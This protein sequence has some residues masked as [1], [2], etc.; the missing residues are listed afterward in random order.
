[1]AAVKS[2]APSATRCPVP[3]TPAGAC[4]RSP[5]ATTEAPCRKA[6]RSRCRVAAQ[7]SNPCLL[8][9]PAELPRSPRWGGPRTRSLP[10]ICAGLALQGGPVGR[11]HR[12][13]TAFA[14]R[15]GGAETA[16]RARGAP[17]TE[18]HE[19]LRHPCTAQ[20][21]PRRPRRPRQDHA[22][23]R[24][25]ARHRHVFEDA[26]GPR[27]PGD[28]LQRPGARAGHHHPGQGR[29]GPWGDVRI[30]LVDTPGHADFG[31]EVERAL[32][33]VDGVLL[34]VDAAEGPLPQT[35]YVL[36]E[37]AGRR[38]ARRRRAQQGRPPGRPGRRGARRDL[39]ALPRPRRLR[40]RHR[41][42]RHLGGRPRGAGRGGRRHA[43]PRRRPHAAVRGHRSTRVP[44][45]DGR[46]RRAAAGH[47]HQPRRVR[48][49]RAPGHRPRRP[50]HA[51]ARASRSPCST[52]SS[53]RA[54]RRCKRTPH[55]AAWASSGIGRQSRSTSASPATCS[56]WPGFPEVEI[57]DTLADPADPE[58]L[59]RLVGRRAGA[60]HDLRGEHLA[61][62]RQ[63]RQVPHVAPPARP[64]RPRGARQRVDPPEPTPPPPTSSRWPAGASSS[65]SV[66]IESMRR[67]GYE[68][69]VSRPRSS[70]AR[71]TA[72]AT[73]PSSAA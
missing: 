67:E 50:G 15:P 22:G 53:P 41:V 10:T 58:P 61:A 12:P 30:N 3:T 57:G 9:R 16:P 59:P 26:P 5:R 66:L 49:P 60:A 2:P 24:H 63:G 62:G 43:R 48:L 72:S 32:A 6:G 28:G 64:A 40:R 46:P 18:P 38:A 68:L 37:G 27:R 51:C 13:Q 42:P 11:L 35:R 1:M 55:L 23:R 39:P 19:P 25:A 69:Q 70:S 33:L 14:K 36:S 29:L 45:P 56:W 7:P 21:R 20:H 44:A 34:L 47:R 71:S 8:A 4:S 52:R 65:S 31:G 73:S 54:S 17:T